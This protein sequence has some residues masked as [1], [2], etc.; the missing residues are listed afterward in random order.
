MKIEPE[1]GTPQVG[2][3]YGTPIPEVLSFVM[4]FSVLWCI[5]IS[6]F[7]SLSLI[8]KERYYYLPH[9]ADDET[10]VG[11]GNVVCFTQLVGDR[12]KATFFKSYFI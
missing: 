3:Q 5:I 12:A 1:K 6:G 8:S 4:G 7:L 9:S 11:L 2:S 10:D